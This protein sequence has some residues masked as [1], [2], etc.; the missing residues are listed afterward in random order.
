[1]SAT[2]L[3]NHEINVIESEL[4]RIYLHQLGINENDVKNKFLKKC[5]V[6]PNGKVRE[7]LLT[8]QKT[9]TLKDIEN[10][11]FSH[12]DQSVKERNGMIFTP[13]NITDYI[14]EETISHKT[15]PK[16]ID[17]SCGY[18]V[19]LYRSVEKLLEKNKN[20]SVIEVIENNIYGIDI[21]E[22][23][24]K[25]TKILL[26]LLAL[27]NK[28]DKEEIKF[29]LICGDATDFHV[30]NKFN[31]SHFDCVVGNP[32]YIKIQDLPVQSRQFL[33]QHYRTMEKGNVNIYFAF[34]E[35]G[36]KYLAEDGILGYIIPNYILKLKAAESLRELLINHRYIKKVIDFKGNKLFDDIQTY[37]CIL[38]LDKKQ[39]KNIQYNVIKKL[40]TPDLSFINNHLRTLDYKD[41][42]KEIINLLDHTERSNIRKI[43]SFPNKLDIST[44]IATQKDKLYLIEIDDRHAEADFYYKRY[45]EKDYKIEKDITVEII[46]GG[47]NIDYENKS[48]KQRYR[49][50]YPYRKNKDGTIHAIPEN[51]MKKNF[52]H[53]YEYFKAIKDELATR[54]KGN[55]S[56]NIWYEYGRS[57]ALDRF[58]PKIISPTNADIP[59][60]TLFKEHALFSNGY[61]IYGIEH[62]IFNEGSELSLEA[63]NKIL[64]SVVM[65][66]Y[67]KNTSYMID[68]G[69]YC[70]Q[71][72]Y[73]KNFTI[74]PFTDE[75]VTWLEN[76]HN[77]EEINKFLIDKY[78]LEI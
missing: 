65:D 41:V 50:I 70:Y 23:N 55:P 12:V 72:K 56:V 78:Q 42:N 71:K 33:K 44:G 36:I 62:S 11:L 28:E 19:F 13:I 61:A 15:N 39:K 4:I 57:Q 6:P 67:I 68:G 75:E 64:N 52:P 20:L 26:T 48:V 35:L 49:I 74:P 2:L 59:K 66:Y 53:T 31:V 21:L 17:F 1:M 27:K 54:N 76:C 29:N 46:K 37:T 60:F 77:E 38:F 40:N 58:S 51:E 32:P 45:N 43:E 10:Y 18:G 47:T 34:V 30:V 22:E 3:A 69:F 5:L 16:I 7:N 14:L 8:F 25:R 73:L 9:W 24:I 63:L